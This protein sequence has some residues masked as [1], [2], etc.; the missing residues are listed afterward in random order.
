M[1]TALRVATNI[2]SLPQ[3]IQF[4]K[5]SIEERVGLLAQLVGKP[6]NQGWEGIEEDMVWVRA[7]YQELLDAVE[8]KDPTN[9]R[10][11]IA[12]LIICLYYLAR[13]AG[14]PVAK[15][16]DE[17]VFSNLTKLDQYK[18]RTRETVERAARNGVSA[19][20]HDTQLDLAETSCSRQLSIAIV[21]EDSQGNDGRFYPK[22]KWLKPTRFAPPELQRL[23]LSVQ[24]KLGMVKVRR[25]AVE[26]AYGQYVELV[27]DGMIVRTYD[28]M[29]FE[30]GVSWTKGEFL[31]AKLR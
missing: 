24:E 8:N 4:S 13:R 18:D 26:H 20:I 11:E 30:D 6:V 14:F 3:M 22:G 12:D 19:Y 7:E 15:D 16:L 25:D 9:L 2:I 21:E 31:L 23:P 10:G 17:I 29:V 5:L 27:P 1:S 28:D